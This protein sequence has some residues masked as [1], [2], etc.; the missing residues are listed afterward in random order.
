MIS[1]P[2]CKPKWLTAIPMVYT[3]DNGL[4]ERDVGLLCLALR[5]IGQD[6]SFAV[7]GP[8]SVRRDGQLIMGTEAQFADVSWWRRWAADVVILTSWGEP[9]F[10]PIARA[11]KQSGSRLLLKLDSHGLVSPRVHFMDY[12]TSSYHRYR[13]VSRPAPLALAIASTLIKFV[14]PQSYDHRLIRLLAHGECLAIESLIAADRLKAFLAAYGR[15]NLARR[16]AVLPHPVSPHMVFDPAVVKAPQIVAVGRWESYVK[17]APLL[18][19]VLAS[20]LEQESEYG[21]RIVGSGN[22]VVSS[23]VR[24]LPA[25]IRQ[26]IS[27]T[28]KVCHQ[29]MPKMYQEARIILVPS[30]FESFHIASAEALCCGCAVVG[31]SG[32]PSMHYFTSHASGTVAVRP[33]AAGLEVALRTEI[34]NWREGRRDPAAIGDW[35]SRELHAG[36]VAHRIKDIL[37]M[38]PVGHLQSG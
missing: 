37:G 35:W 27:I 2:S 8:P 10:E 11:V 23:L 13:D 32:I 17:N 31:P 19:S 28:G 26:R 6:C 18:V 36:K 4:W 20:V 22:D 3:E 34:A 38:G 30:R 5:E 24:R 16:V 33:D 1:P 15:D 7:L 12:L 25:G 14:V 29:C 21:A 9:R